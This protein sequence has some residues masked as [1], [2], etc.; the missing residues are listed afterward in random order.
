MRRHVLLVSGWRT[1]RPRARRIGLDRSLGVDAWLESPEE[2]SARLRELIAVFRFATFLLQPD[3]NEHQQAATTFLGTRLF[4]LSLD[5]IALHHVATIADDLATRLIATVESGL[6]SL[7]CFLRRFA[8]RFRCLETSWRTGG[9]PAVAA[10]IPGVSRRTAYRSAP[11]MEAREDLQWRREA[12]GIWEIG[13]PPARRGTHREQ[14]D[15][16][17]GRRTAENLLEA[18]WSTPPCA[19][20]ARRAGRRPTNCRRRR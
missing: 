19:D 12:P 17:S 8:A 18:A 14:R 9:A 2:T 11:V 4:A 20:P 7:Q 1:D 16:G 10:Q 13:E 15:T 5:G 6:Q 3:P